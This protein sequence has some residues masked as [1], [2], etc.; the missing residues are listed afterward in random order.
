MLDRPTARV[1]KLAAR[2]CKSGSDA[3][4]VEELGLDW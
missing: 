1:K 2:G 3:R 4:E